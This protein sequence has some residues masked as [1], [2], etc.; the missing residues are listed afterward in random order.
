MSEYPHNFIEV[1]KICC[2]LAGIYGIVLSEG[3]DA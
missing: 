3:K 1:L 2:V